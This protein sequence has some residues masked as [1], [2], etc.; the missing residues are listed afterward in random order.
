MPASGVSDNDIFL[1]TWCLKN[2]KNFLTAKKDYP[3]VPYQWDDRDNYSKDYT[4]LSEFYDKT[5]SDFSEN[6]NE[7]HN[8]DKSKEYWRII[9]G[10]WL[11]FCIDALYDR[12]ECVRTASE[13]SQITTCTL[14][15][16]DL[17]EWHPRDFHD[18]WN[19][20]VSDE[21]NEVV[22]SECVKFQDLPYDVDRNFNI[23]P[24]I[25]PN[26]ERSKSNQLKSFIKSL[27]LPLFST[28]GRINT[29]VVF[30]SP[31]VK[32]SKVLKLALKLR[33]VPY[34]QNTQFT[35]KDLVINRGKRNL[36]RK[37]KVEDGFEKFARKLL[38]SLIP[39]SYLENFSLIRTCVL[40]RLPNKPKRVFTANAYQAD[41]GFKIWIAEKKQL[42]CKL[43]IGQH[44]GHFGVGKFNQTVDHQLLIASSFISWGWRCDGQ[45]HIVKLPSIQLSGAP[46][47]SHKKDGFILHIHS[48]LPRYFYCHYSI[49][50]A[51][52]F[53]S[54]LENQLEFAKSLDNCSREYYKIRLDPSSGSCGWNIEAQYAS[55]G[56]SEKIDHSKEGLWTQIK[57]SR[58][59]VCSHNATV[60]LE[61][62]SR[63]FPT[64]VFWDERFN[65]IS[66]D[67]KPLIELLSD[68][69]M[70]FYCP[71]QAAK[72]V[73]SISEDIDAW[74]SSE[75]VQSAR[76][77]FCDRYAL[78]SKN[79]AKEWGDFLMRN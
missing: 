46:E 65:E 27:V 58:L 63:N 66:T 50:V 29:D 3:I 39:K 49:P 55:L 31:Y 12:F 78:T 61:T 34:V 64:I 14:G 44:G 8:T 21:W 17:N 68:A 53:L 71:K 22:L 15:I 52:Q 48:S 62:L 16:Y 36:F 43:I 40:K 6:L 11:R 4:Y 57:K 10:P 13:N 45:P 79:W 18:F 41:D 51:G 20:F 38:P 28:I 37:S 2:F 33:Q 60:F 19:D 42:G 26:G 69:E 47:L 23:K 76:I 25:N 74:W 73:N 32:F 30:V 7:V 75:K 5:L 70:L 72:K 67:S 9:I 56:Y 59:C 1:G 24:L 54:Y 35:V 77:K